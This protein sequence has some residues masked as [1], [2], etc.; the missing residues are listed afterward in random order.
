MHSPCSVLFFC[1]ALM[2]LSRELP[3][4][5]TTHTAAVNGYKT[6]IFADFIISATFE[7]RTDSCQEVI[8]QFKCLT[9]LLSCNTIDEC[10]R[11]PDKFLTR[12]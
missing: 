6:F 10:I 12:F 1:S 2:A 8:V 7:K 9:G 11:L 4:P 5:A 3:P